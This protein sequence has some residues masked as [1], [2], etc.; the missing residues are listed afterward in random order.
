[1]IESSPDDN[2]YKDE[3]ELE[4]YGYKESTLEEEAG[5]SAPQEFFAASTMSSDDS[6]F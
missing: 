5:E 6:E 2:N 4:A 3:D 1:M